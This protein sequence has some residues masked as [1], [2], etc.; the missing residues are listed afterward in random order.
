MPK[1]LAVAQNYMHIK[2][3]P[4]ITTHQQFEVSALARVLDQP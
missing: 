2:E 1:R 4:P 3:E